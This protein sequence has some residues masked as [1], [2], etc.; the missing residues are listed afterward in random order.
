MKTSGKRKFD[1]LTAKFWQQGLLNQSLSKSNVTSISEPVQ[2]Y[3][4]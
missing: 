3:L 1:K 2:V 4:R